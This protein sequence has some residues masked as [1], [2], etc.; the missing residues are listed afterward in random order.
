MKLPVINLFSTPFEKWEMRNKTFDEMLSSKS[1]LD[2]HT[3]IPVRRLELISN[4]VSA[5][6]YVGR[7]GNDPE[8]ERF[9]NT[10]LDNSESYKKW[11]S[12]M[13]SI[14]PMALRNYQKKFHNC[15]L[16]DVSLTI[17][18]IGSVLSEGQYLFHG[19][20]WPHE[21]DGP[22]KEKFST[23]R[24]LSTSFCPQ[25]AI[26]NAAYSGK[27]YDKGY[28]DLFVLK[29]VTPKTKVFSYK[30]AGTTHGHENEVL[31]SAN[32]QLVLKDKYIVTNCHPVGKNLLKP[33]K[34]P[35]F[36]FE[37]EIS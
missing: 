7:V 8:F 4:A 32:A 20:H 31:F 10:T 37:A 21:A 35:I 30:R 12:A 33:R 23:V 14:T 34:V 19:G 28:I 17:N 1:H 22:L 2:W 11:K 9:I 24:P 29:T 36:V 13:P 3:M 15:N 25:I 6:I 27:A 16:D 18:N 5:A 26:R